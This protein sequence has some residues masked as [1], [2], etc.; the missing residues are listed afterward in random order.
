MGKGAQKDAATALAKRVGAPLSDKPGKEL[1]LLIDGNGVSLN[2]YGLTFKGDFEQMLHRLTEGRLQHEMISRVC[3]TKETGLKAIDA[4]AGMGED[5]ILLAANGYDVTLHEQN[6]VIAALLK[7]ALRRGKKHPVLKEIVERMHLVEGDSVEL[8]PKRVDEPELIFL[9]PMFPERQKS[10]LINKKL[11]LIQ[12]LERP[13]TEESELFDA[14]IAAHPKKII[15]KRPLKGPYLAD[16]E[17]TYTVK[18]KA[19]RYDVYIYG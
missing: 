6:P 17:P 5:S 7:D 3:K 18:G 16:R 4:T 9:D 11:Q 8:M 1:T 14:A 19:I 2:G 13:C 15:V 10:G 12:K